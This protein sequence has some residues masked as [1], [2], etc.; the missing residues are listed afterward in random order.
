LNPSNNYKILFISHEATRSGAPRALL[1]LAGWIKKNTNLQ[2]E[3]LLLNDGPLRPEFESLGK[4]F[5]LNSI[6]RHHTY[7]GRIKNRLLR[8]TTEKIYKKATN[9]LFKRGYNLVYGNTILTLPWLKIFKL[10]YG[11]KTVC[12]VHELA[13]S[14]NYCFSDEYLSKNLPLMDSII[15]VSKAVK[16]NLKN[17]YNLPEEKIKL[18]YEFIDTDQKINNEK[19]TLI[20]ELGIADGEFIVGAGG[21][22]EWRKG[23]DLLIPLAQ[24]LVKNYP[25]LKFRIIWLGADPTDQFVKQIIFDINKCGIEGRFIF[26]KS[27]PNPLN[28]INIFDVF[29]LLSREDPFPL[30]ALEAAL[31]K[32][33]L[34]AFEQSGGI[35][36]LI[37]QGAGL[38]VPYL[39]TSIA[40]DCIYQLTQDQELNRKLGNKA[41]ELVA[42]KYSTGVISPE[43]Y[44][45]LI[46]LISN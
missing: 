5:I 16:E 43:I 1:N 12:C 27:K 22:P 7:S 46:E 24:N 13:F 36:E 33:P 35:P 2:T 9:R 45:H 26:L 31:L 10:D 32:K 30:I 3:F 6:T 15:A 18:H 42:T 29:I 37:I 38:L 8:V 28:Y 39:N 34:I 40:A 11:L 19:T 21:A 25:D 23:T 44:E 14:L 20:N 4:T 41:H 17:S